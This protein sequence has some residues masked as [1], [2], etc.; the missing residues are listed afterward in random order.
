MVQVAIKERFPKC[1]KLSGTKQVV[2]R[3]FLFQYIEFMILDKKAKDLLL[4][5][6]R[7]LE[8]EDEFAV[9]GEPFKKIKRI[10]TRFLF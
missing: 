6:L 4:D 2:L 8:D 3:G 9:F 7:L 10:V 5:F 1:R